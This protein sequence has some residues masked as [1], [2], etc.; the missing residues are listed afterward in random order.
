MGLHILTYHASNAIRT[1]K[2]L[3]ACRAISSSNRHV[4]WIFEVNF[5]G[6][7]TT[8]PSRLTPGNPRGQITVLVRFQ[9]ICFLWW[10]TCE[11]TVEVELYF[12]CCAQA[13][14]DISYWST[15]NIIG[16]VK[17]VS[18]WREL[19]YW[20]RKKKKVVHSISEWK[21]CSLNHFW[22]YIKLTVFC[23]SKNTK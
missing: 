7:S 9:V 11:E 12:C 2:S 18:W 14:C 6:T 8:S 10:C 4:L 13:L 5:L 23:M 1:E 22:S 15:K 3:T 20:E 21:L 19:R 17:T 16:Y